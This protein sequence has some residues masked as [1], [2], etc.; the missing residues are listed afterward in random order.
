LEAV[1]ADRAGDRDRDHDRSAPALE[2]GGVRELVEYCRLDI[3][4]LRVLRA[5]GLPA[6][7]M[8]TE[9]LAWA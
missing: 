5:R 1:G 3:D 6:R 7:L 4:W 8:A 2:L 9:V